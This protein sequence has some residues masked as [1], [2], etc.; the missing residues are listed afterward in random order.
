MTRRGVGRGRHGHRYTMSKQLRTPRQALV[1]GESTDV[2][3]WLAQSAAWQGR[4]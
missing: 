4:H 3:A 1:D 2:A